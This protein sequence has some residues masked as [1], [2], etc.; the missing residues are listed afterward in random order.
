M[1]KAIK[2][3][4]SIPAIIFCQVNKGNYCDFLW[5][6]KA[7]RLMLIFRTLFPWLHFK[8]LFYK[9]AELTKRWLIACG[10]VLYKRS[11][12]LF[13]D[14]ASENEKLFIFNFLMII[15][16]IDDDLSKRMIDFASSTTN[17]NY[18]YWVT[19]NIDK[20]VFHKQRGYYDDY[21]ID[22]KKLFEMIALENKLEQKQS[23]ENNAKKTICIITYLLDYDLSNSMQRVATMFCNGLRDYY[24]EINVL[25]LEPFSINNRMV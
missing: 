23:D 2:G 14:G 21:Y 15:D 6:K 10:D 24:D 12:S 17:K 16:L 3:F 19:M 1:K 5:I 22:R 20:L 11:L 25:S 18:R 7:T 13:F 9:H 4:L 8:H